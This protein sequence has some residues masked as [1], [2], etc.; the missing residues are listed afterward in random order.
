MRLGITCYP[1][2]GG[3]GIL[4]TRL[5]VELSRRGHEVHFITYERPVAIQGVDHENVFVHL[6]SVIEYP[7]FKYPPYTVAL[8]SEMFRVSKQHGLDLIHVHYAIPHSTA[9]LLA[10][11]MTGVP[12]VVTLHGSDVTILGGDPS[13]LPV[14]TFS[15]ESADGLTAVSRYLVERAHDGLGISRDITVIPNFVDSVAFSPARPD[16]VEGHN[17]RQVVVA[18]I[19]NFRPVK[20]VQDLVVAMSRVVEEVEDTR[21][22]LVG[23]GPERHRIELLVEKLGLHRNVLL[24]GYRRDIPNLLRCSDILVLCS[25]IESSPLTL[26]EAMS[27][28][29]PIIAT[30]V[31][32]IPDIVADGRNGFLVP[33]NS[34][35]ELAEKILELNS[36]AELRLRM[37][38]AAR[39]TILE[40]FTADKVVPQYEE[41]YRRAASG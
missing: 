39:R 32:G 9:A 20:R 14:N 21:L 16:V 27:S 23:D 1:S 37:G 12:Y 10:R 3:S 8:G 31:G 38:A 17:G 40:R 26:L 4:A 34:P 18:H 41:A 2:V 7:L 33:P 25:E 5:G 19:S 29:L 30:E 24:T 11:M 13:F 15:I 35:E 28:G 6:V 36:D 22:L